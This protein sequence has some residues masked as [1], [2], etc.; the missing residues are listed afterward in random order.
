MMRVVRT[1]AGLLPAVMIAV[2]AL[3]VANAR[4]GESAAAARPD[5]G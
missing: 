3:G 4:P 2:A 1:M 5:A